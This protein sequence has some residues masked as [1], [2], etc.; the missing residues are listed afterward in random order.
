MDFSTLILLAGGAL[1]FLFGLTGI[2]D[3]DFARYYVHTRMKV[4]PVLT[5]EG[6]RRAIWM[7]R[8]VYGPLGVVGGAGLIVAVLFGYVAL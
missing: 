1:S 8:R 7:L 4:G 5:P 3:E 6:E 2:L